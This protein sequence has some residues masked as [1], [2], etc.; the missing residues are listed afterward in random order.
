MSDDVKSLADIAKEK[1]VSPLKN[2]E[3]ERN[4]RS[5]SSPVLLYDMFG[6]DDNE[7]AAHPGPRGGKSE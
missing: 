1:G 2:S 4:V 7:P 5:V 6:E 3:Y